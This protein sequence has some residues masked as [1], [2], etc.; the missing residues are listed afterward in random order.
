MQK[1]DASEQRDP[2]EA[3]QRKKRSSKVPSEAQQQSGAEEELLM[4]AEALKQTKKAEGGAGQ[5]SVESD[6]AKAASAAD[7]FRRRAQREV[8]VRPL[9][10][11]ATEADIRG[12]F[13]KKSGKTKWLGAAV[14]RVKLVRMESADA[15]SAAFVTFKTLEDAQLC[16]A[17]C[18]G[19]QLRGQTLSMSFTREREGAK[20]T[21]M[22]FLEGKC[23]RGKWCNFAHPANAEVAAPV[24]GRRLPTCKFFAA[25][26]CSRGTACKFSHVIEDDAE[27]QP[28]GDAEEQGKDGA[29]QG[30]LLLD[31]SV[32]LPTLF[33][34]EDLLAVNKPAGVLSHP[35]PGYW[36]GGTVAHGLVGRVSDIM[37]RPRTDHKEEDSYIPRAIVHRLDQGTTGVMAV[38]KTPMAERQL[39]SVLR[40]TG[41]AGDRL[42]KKTY[43]ALL[44]GRPGGSGRP[45]RVDVDAALGRD[46]WDPRRMAV[47]PDGRAASSVVHVHCHHKAHGATLATVQIL[48]GRM[49]QIRVHCAHLGAPIAG[50]TVYGDGKVDDSFREA[51][52]I[53]GFA[54]RPLLHAWALDLPHPRQGKEPLS[55][56]APLPDDMRRVIA[57]LWPELPADPAL[58]PGPREKPKAPAKRRA[59]RRKGE[60]PEGGAGA[61]ADAPA[62]AKKR[63]RR[64]PPG[65]EEEPAGAPPAEAPRQ[66]KKK[67]KRK[68]D[69]C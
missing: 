8:F 66:L 22:F 24:S 62:V 65:Q 14:E 60:E 32:S 2:E 6:A 10:C 58:W 4:K 34:D 17:E 50:D 47:T 27:A 57:E 28:A 18:N 43:A 64:P 20:E 68:D 13:A 49:H 7:F 51:L 1:A 46:P 33:E 5:P 42:V 40:A 67:K 21:C 11:D 9:P 31:P 15:R 36:D 69:A 59:K 37:L 26:R 41:S 12:I 54:R 53:L 45:R 63:K 23:T 25:G 30:K 44:L 61:E 19:V 3:R 16:V 39:A 48:T 35:S 38:A 29:G 55:L 52:G 56:R